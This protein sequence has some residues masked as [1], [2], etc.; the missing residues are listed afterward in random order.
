MTVPAPN[1]TVKIKS[2]GANAGHYA[3]SIKKVS[4]LGYKGNSIGNKKLTV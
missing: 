1:T 4:L 3:Q 2:L